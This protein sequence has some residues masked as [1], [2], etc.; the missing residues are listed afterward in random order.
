MCSETE[1]LK[2]RLCK[3]EKGAQI[4]HKLCET[5]NKNITEEIRLTAPL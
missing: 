5:L 2:V 3:T 1:R 4:E